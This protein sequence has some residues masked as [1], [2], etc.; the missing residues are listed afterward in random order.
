M[1]QPYEVIIHPRREKRVKPSLLTIASLITIV[2][3]PFHIAGDVALGFDKGGPGLVYVVVPVLL[4]V[5]CGTLLLAERRSGHVIMFL[6]GLA[7]LGMPIIHR[8]NG[9]TQAV[10]TSPGG[11]F[12]IWTLVALGVTGGLAMI[13]SARGLWNLRSR[14]N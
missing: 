1:R 9:F 10:A 13:L 6:G 7:A 14:K 5:A 8:N 11:L 12:F 4:L 3:L 2:L